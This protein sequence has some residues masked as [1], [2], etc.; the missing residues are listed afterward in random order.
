MK[1]YTVHDENKLIM[2]V[3]LYISKISEVYFRN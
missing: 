3:N 2:T 1:F